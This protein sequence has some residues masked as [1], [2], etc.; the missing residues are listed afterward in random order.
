MCPT[1]AKANPVLFAALEA[2]A[3]L[4]DDAFSSLTN[5]SDMEALAVNSQVRQ[6]NV[7]AKSRAFYHSFFP[8]RSQMVALLANTYRQYFKLVLAHP[9]QAGERPE[10]WAWLQLQ[11]AIRAA[12]EWMRDW[13]VLACDG[14]NR[15]LVQLASVDFI[16]A[17]TV[18]IPLQLSNSSVAMPEPWRAPAWLFGVSLAVFGVGVLKKSHIPDKESTERLGL[19]HTRLLLKGAKRIFIWDLQ[20]AVTRVK[21]EEIA[22]AGAVR[23]DPSAV[24]ERRPNKR[25][26]WEQRLKLF[27]AI[28][29]ILNASPTLEGIAFCGELDKRHAL[30]LHDWSVSGEWR[31]GLTWKEAWANRELRRK[32]RRVRQE[33]Q[34]EG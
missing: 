7:D 20:K 2:V 11:P 13:Y 26:G 6:G 3:N 33:A 15:K 24:L 32:I 21:D 25:K 10:L 27:A 17:G 30:P 19:S 8:L 4:C 22:A 16:P 34:R 14:Q 12:L 5:R 28:R 23:T 31:K 1:K 18:T 29:K 9:K